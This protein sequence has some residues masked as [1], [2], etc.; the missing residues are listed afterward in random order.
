MGMV[1]KEEKKGVAGDISIDC[2]NRATPPCFRMTLW[3][4]MLISVF[5][6]DIEF[7]FLTYVFESVS[8]NVLISDFPVAF[9]Q[10]S[11]KVRLVRVLVFDAQANSLISDF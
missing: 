4:L 5:S 8:N 9:A 1:R 7:S 10:D 11:S 6:R 3:F 2:G